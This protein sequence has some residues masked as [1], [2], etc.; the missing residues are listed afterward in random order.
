[1]S[2]FFKSEYVL[3]WDDHFS[4]NLRALLSEWIQNFPRIKK[5]DLITEFPDDHINF[6]PGMDGF[7]WNLYRIKDVLYWGFNYMYEIVHPNEIEYPFRIFE[8]GYGDF[9][10]KWWSQFN[11]LFS[12]LNNFKPILKLGLTPISISIYDVH[13][14]TKILPFMLISNDDEKNYDM[15]NNLLNE[16]EEC[17]KLWQELQ[18]FR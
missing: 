5:G 12:Q 17:K 16:I 13:Y 10:E 14:Q 11:L 4:I 1:M 9:L 2:H 15:V 6:E 7:S 3:Y 18:R 8:I